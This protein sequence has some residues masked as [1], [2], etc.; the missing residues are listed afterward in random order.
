MKFNLATK[1]IVTNQLQYISQKKTIAL[2]INE[3]SLEIISQFFP[4]LKLY[5][6]IHIETNNKHPQKSNSN[7]LYANAN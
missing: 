1:L 2:D 7:M 5:T 3:E 6:I 4:L